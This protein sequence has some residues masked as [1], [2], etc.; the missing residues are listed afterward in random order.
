MVT[1]STPSFYNHVSWLNH[2]FGWLNH[3]F[4]LVDLVDL[5]DLHIFDACPTPTILLGP[6]SLSCASKNRVPVRAPQL[7]VV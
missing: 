1:S 2:K 5:V 7:L 3:D 6:G 4:C